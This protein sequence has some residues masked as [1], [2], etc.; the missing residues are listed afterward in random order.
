MEPL[1]TRQILAYLKTKKTCSLKEL[2]EKFNVS[3]ATIHR[4]VEA[5]ARRDAIER[6]RGGVV[7]NDAMTTKSMMNSA[8]YQERV[9]ANRREKVKIADAALSRIQDGDIVFLDSS[10]TVYELA[11]RMIH[12]NFA[13]LSVVT[14]AISVMHLFRKFPTH[15][16]MIGLGGNYDP[17]LN[18]ILGISAMEQLKSFNVTKAFM[19][20]F[21]V[22]DQCATTNHERQAEILR[23]VI[24]TAAKSYLLADHTKI[25]RTG[26][27]RFASRSAFSDVITD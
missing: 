1:R 20:C 12:E 13:H 9:V 19:S 5:L 7:F 16:A 2:M 23:Q 3:S 10:T 6:V 11:V 4:D 24:G 17:Q 25:D 8:D 26:L 15:W 18:S 22:D 27:Y 21:G 14:N